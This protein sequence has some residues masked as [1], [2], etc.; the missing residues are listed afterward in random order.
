MNNPD[1]GLLSHCN[2]AKILIKLCIL[3]VI[4]EH[5]CVLSVW[6]CSYLYVREAVCAQMYLF[7]LVQCTYIGPT[8]HIHN[9]P[10]SFKQIHFF[11]PNL[12]R[13]LFLKD[14]PGMSSISPLLLTGNHTHLFN[15]IWNDQPVVII[16][17]T[18][19]SYLLQT[20]APNRMLVNEPPEFIH[21]VTA[22]ER[23]QKD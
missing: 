8:V 16:Y 4:A 9:F 15:L 3:T 17:L 10:L 21:L 5:F 19:L 22:L 7:P 18:P 6:V 1:D 20:T 23:T 13:L 11:T 2:R 12:F 14:W